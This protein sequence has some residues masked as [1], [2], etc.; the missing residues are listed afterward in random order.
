MH[1]Y[2][3]LTVV[4]LVAV[5]F[6]TPSY[7]MA[8]QDY[9]V[10]S[11]E[12]DLNP[13]HN[14]DVVYNRANASLTNYDTWYYQPE[15]RYMG[16]YIPS[17][18]F[19]LNTLITNNR[20]IFLFQQHINFSFRD[21]VSGISD[22]WIRLPIDTHPDNI[23]YLNLTIWRIEGENATGV[24]AHSDSLGV[25]TCSPA[26]RADEVYR[27]VDRI[28][29]N[30]NDRNITTDFNDYFTIEH[31][32]GDWRT[33]LRL[34]APIYPNTNY[35]F[36]TQVQY[37]VTSPE[38]YPVFYVIGDDLASDQIYGSFVTHLSLTEG[39]NSIDFP[40]DLDYS[41]IFLTGTGGAGAVNQF[42]IYNQNYQSGGA[43][44][45]RFNEFIFRFPW[46]GYTSGYYVNII[47]PLHCE[48]SHRFDARLTAHYIDLGGAQQTEDFGLQ[49]NHTGKDYL[50]LNFTKAV[51]IVP[52]E[53]ESAYWKLSIRLNHYQM[54]KSV[55]LHLPLRDIDD[56]TVE[57]DEYVNHDKVEIRQG[58][59]RL[60]PAT[61]SVSTNSSYVYWSL[62]SAC[63]VIDGF[64]S[65]VPAVGPTYSR[66]SGFAFILEQNYNNLIAVIE[67]SLGEGVA[68]GV[69]ILT[70]G[71]YTSA[72]YYLEMQSAIGKTIANGI[73]TAGEAIVNWMREG[74]NAI[75]DGLDWLYEKLQDLG[76]WIRSVGQRLGDWF[77]AL[78]EQIYYYLS[79]AIGF[80]I[81]ILCVV[82]FVWM[83]SK[84]WQA[85][86][87][88]YLIATGSFNEGSAALSS[89]VGGIVSNV[90]G[91][92]EKGATVATAGKTKI[93]AARRVGRTQVKRIR[94]LKAKTTGQYRRGRV[95]ISKL[96]ASMRMRRDN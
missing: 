65:F 34:Q 93:I 94:G 11:I 77:T 17:S 48:A 24:K 56:P 79:G 51:D 33:Y 21:V 90:G 75:R 46:E 26:D 82:F 69:R 32:N 70:L 38:S 44:Y 40:T 27:V 2:L 53:V 64:Y 9:L 29:I 41:F 88:V 63:F 18:K 80:I 42:E 58:R 68:L 60:N 47:L 43:N 57:D 87:A 7:A 83:V 55:T 78:F 84:W 67:N 66:W 95:R 12:L 62:W 20:N 8:T 61:T 59:F 76:N 54:T 72:L 85:N 30:P 92:I 35:L 45:T 50:I 71:I 74:A 4:M 91:A 37:N 36:I 39:V 25:L 14:Y 89:M 96:K 73:M 31:D 6:F 16:A 81:L 52:R 19:E 15:G 28:Q 5:L 49:K 3:H 10:E 1:R 22:M 86:Y 23:I 13:V